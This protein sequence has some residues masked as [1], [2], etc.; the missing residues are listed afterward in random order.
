MGF[1]RAMLRLAVLG[2][3]ALGFASVASADE[4]L[5]SVPVTLPVTPPIT[6]AVTLA[7]A[8]AQAVL[9][10]PA[11]VDARLAREV[12]AAQLPAAALPSLQN[13]VAEFGIER[14]SAYLDVFTYGQLML[15]F[16]VSGQ[17]SSRMREADEILRAREAR[18]VLTK[19]EI[20]GAVTEA[21]GAVVTARARIVEVE[22]GVAAA[23]EEERIHRARLFAGDATVLDVAS[24]EAELGRWRQ[25]KRTLELGL[26]GSNA[27]F[28]QLLGAS[29]RIPADQLLPPDVTVSGDKKV[30]P[31]AALFAREAEAF[32]AAADRSRSEARGTFDVG[33]RF[34]RG[35]FGELRVGVIAS[36]PLTL[37]R[38]NQAEVARS[39]AEATRARTMSG[40]AER[41]GGIRTVSAFERCA[42]ARE[43]LKELDEFAVPAAERAVRAAQD[44]F[45]AGKAD[46]FRVLLVRR[47]L[48][49]TRMRRLDIVD[50]EWAAY[51]ELLVLGAVEP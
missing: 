6:P 50:L 46:F 19:A 18:V 4:S 20:A 2:F 28:F 39:E 1:R 35:D 51:A 17:R 36:M 21:F 14:G 16:E 9:E 30:F 44:A 27:R 3:A 38:R 10:A 33:P 24:A 26:V 11:A 29:S 12:Q 32:T 40:L 22:R 47:D 45:R 41:T 37:I 5:A 7:E 34:T 25:S 49:A 48:V 23:E 43:A 8:I 31:V 15:R 13:P 42:R